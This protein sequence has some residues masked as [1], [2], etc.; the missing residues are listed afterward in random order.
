VVHYKP[1]VDGA[2]ELAS[3][4]PDFCV[5]FQREQ[6]VATLVAD[7]DVDWHGFQAG[8]EPAECLPVEGNHP[9]YVLYTSGTTGAPK[10]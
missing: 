3:H 7:R 2:I 1:L 10:G 9:A 8:V 6:E 4:K 5:I